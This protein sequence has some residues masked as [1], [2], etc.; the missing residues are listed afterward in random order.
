M[1]LLIIGG[2]YSMREELLTR[3]GEKR[4][5]IAQM[6]INQTNNLFYD[7][8]ES[9]LSWSSTAIMQD[10][11]NGETTQRIQHLLSSNYIQTGLF[12]DITVTDIEGNIVASALELGPNQAEATW[13]KNVIE[14]REISYNQFAYYEL[15]EGFSI[16]I[17]SPIYSK[18]SPKKIIGTI[19]GFFSWTRLLEIIHSLEIGDNA[20]STSN[21]I[22]LIDQAG[23]T[24]AGPQFTLLMD[25]DD[26]SEILKTVNFVDLGI[27]EASMATNGQSG[28][29]LTNYHNN[30][31]LIAFASSNSQRQLQNFSWGVLLFENSD[32]V[33]EPIVKLRN[34]GFGLTL[35]SGFFIFVMTF[36]IARRFTAPLQA[37]N[38]GAMRISHGDYNSQLTVDRDDEIGQ[39]SVMFNSMAASLRQ[40]NHDIEHH[41]TELEVARDKAMVADQAKSDFLSN[42]SHE[43]RTP[44]NT[45]I[46]FSQI[47]IR[48]SNEPNTVTLLLKVKS[49]SDHLMSLLNNI[50]DLSK[51]DAEQTR[52]ERS[53]FSMH[54][55]MHNLSNMFGLKLQKANISFFISI[56]PNIPHSLIGDEH[57]LQQVLTNLVGNATKFI[58]TGTIIVEVS[59]QENIEQKMGSTN[60][61]RFSVKDTGIGIKPEVV[62]GLFQRFTQADESLTREYGGTGLGLSISENI[63]RLMEGSIWVETKLGQ[64]SDFYFTCQIK[65]DPNCSQQLENFKLNSAPF[66]WLNHCSNLY[67]ST[68]SQSF[69]CHFLSYRIEESFSTL[70][71][72]EKRN[73]IVLLDYQHIIYEIEK[74][75]NKYHI[76]NAPDSVHFIFSISTEADELPKK[77][78][79]LN[80]TVIS[81]PINVI[82]LKKV[83]NQISHFPNTA[84]I[85]K[86]K[87]APFT[88]TISPP[89]SISNTDTDTD[90]TIVSTLASTIDTTTSS[91]NNPL[92]AVKIL[93][94]D[95]IEANTLLLKLIFESKEIETVDI[96]INGKE[97]VDA[98]SRK[99]YDVVL[100]DVQMPVMNGLVATELIRKQ[101]SAIDLPIIA[102]TANAMVGDK[103]ECLSVGM[104]EYISKPINH[105]ALFEM[106]SR[107][108]KKEFLTPQDIIR[109]ASWREALPVST[110][111]NTGIDEHGWPIQLDG[112]DI[113]FAKSRVRNNMQFYLRLLEKFFSQF[114]PIMK[115]M[116]SFVSDDDRE[117]LIRE[118]HKLAGTSGNLG[119]KE[120]RIH[121]RFLEQ[122]LRKEDR[123]DISVLFENCLH[124]F[125]TITYSFDKLNLASEP[126]TTAK[127]N[128]STTCQPLQK[129]QFFEGVSELKGALLLSDIKSVEL[130]KNIA[131][132]MPEYMDQEITNLDTK[133][134]EIEHLISNFQFANALD[135]LNEI[136]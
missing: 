38:H 109:P 89:T 4:L 95:D 29:A 66:I 106:L 110:T 25:D 42:M 33:F 92:H 21:Y 123:N 86:L 56:D 52:L 65:T 7:A 13:F 107:V 81:Y 76:A 68:V 47:L 49:A 60:T 9:I 31:Q 53:P 39:L 18:A 64:G 121:A 119:F 55:V 94:V 136:S 57:R 28:F 22:V 98:I 131:W 104:N 61:L 23:H 80:H 59:L 35:V 124:S 5:Q 115:N 100:M 74:P 130:Y 111:E 67:S 84:I 3:Q 128:V 126:A 24:I 120:L 69:D 71:A 105:V 19:V 101:Y 82:I 96:A 117:Q 12:S 85:S 113:A 127:T 93:I 88:T 27:K 41:I 14:N 108:L 83:I 17:A 48:K 58:K 1:I 11:A 114:E 46:G 103:E 79:S 37:L 77:L 72:E 97:A 34:V 50:L 91:E 62:N 63:V 36:F 90:A 54:S 2:Y 125:E 10:L 70:S 45:I 102:M 132:M 134:A 129:D 118:A 73:C 30:E 122:S 16:P 26:E 112:I 44:M 78:L 116:A 15:P 99:K 135:R 8:T 20:G 133:I 32:V 75:N 87:S 40:K 43:I 51:M 6:A